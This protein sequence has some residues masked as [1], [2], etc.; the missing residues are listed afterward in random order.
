MTS[1]ARRSITFAG[2][3]GMSCIGCTMG[4]NYHEPQIAV[5]AAF[6]A[7]QKSGSL[8]RWW[9]QFDDP[10]LNG[11]VEKAVNNNLDLQLAEA[12]VREARA[13]REFIVAG[14]FPEVDTSGTYQRTQISTN[15]GVG[16]LVAGSAGAGSSGGTTGSG[17]TGGSNAGNTPAIRRANP[18]ASGSAGAVGFPSRFTLWQ[19]GFDASWEIDVFGATRRAVEA[20]TA[21]LQAQQEARRDALVTLLGE[22]ATN[23]VE[24]R[25]LQREIDIAGQNIK[26]QQETVGLT[27][28]RFKAGLATDLDVARAQAQVETTRATVPTFRTMLKRSTHRL[29]VLLGQDPELLSAALAPDKPIPV[30]PPELPVGLPSELLRRRPDVR[31]AER[32]LASATAR[33]GV[34][35]AELFPR[36]SLTGS[37]GFQS[38]QLKS[39][40][41]GS[42]IFWNYGPS[43]RWPIFD[44]GKLWAN[45]K[46]ENAREQESLIQYKQ[47]VL[48]AL[49]DVDNAL[50]ALEQEQ[51][52]R[53]SLRAAVAAD[54]RAVDL[55]QQL[56]TK[57]L[58][59]FLNVLDSQ[60]NLFAAQDQLVQSE[61]A[62]SSNLVALYKALGGGWEE[63]DLIAAN[64]K[65]ATPIPQ[66]NVATP[67][68]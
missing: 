61:R 18:A 42:S 49:E 41:N 20:A 37:F 46:I 35:V 40:T 14:L 43:I 64:D 26:S 32:Q 47:T 15:G 6:A 45:V 38:Q 3:L 17:G 50:V 68:P 63:A 13:Q 52:R 36:F 2:A 54:Q 21:D 19:A 66:S 8:E 57:G 62:V 10:Q 67:K 33:A 53:T 31:R 4:R 27:Q 44:A 9:T 39:L 24:V 11:L 1:A 29:G 55:S 65:N 58:A 48:T 16:G 60:R 22:V 59:D 7:E 56:Y 34:A 5:P 51:Q 25:G 30:A 28:S 12:R 23:Y